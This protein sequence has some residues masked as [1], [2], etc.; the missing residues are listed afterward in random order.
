MGW[1]SRHAL[2]GDESQR[3]QS[4]LDVPSVQGVGSCPHVTDEELVR[5]KVSE[6]SRS[7]A[8]W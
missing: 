4:V 8:L 3:V 2:Q 7:G 1:R 5:E 6:L